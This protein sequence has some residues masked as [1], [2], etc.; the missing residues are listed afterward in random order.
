MLFTENENGKIVE[1]IAD[2]AAAVV[3][4]RISNNDKKN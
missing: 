1:S 2:A 4:L 3:L